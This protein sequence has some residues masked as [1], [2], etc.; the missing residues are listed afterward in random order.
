MMSL[1]PVLID[2][3]ASNNAFPRWLIDVG[4]NESLQL[5]LFHIIFNPV[6]SATKVKLSEVGVEHNWRECA[7]EIWIERMKFH[8]GVVCRIVF[9]FFTTEDDSH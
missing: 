3:N 5:L 7:E 4:F 6:L 8:F 1:S 9:F 2:L